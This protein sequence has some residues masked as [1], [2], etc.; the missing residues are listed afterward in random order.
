MRKPATLALWVLLGTSIA[1]A[2]A[3]PLTNGDFESGTLAGWT[4]GSENGGLARIARE[5][6][7]FSYNNTQG[8]SL[9]GSFAAEIR[10]SGPAPVDSTGV[11]T[12]DPFVAGSS[13][14]FNA[15]TEAEDGEHARF[16]IADPVTFEARLLDASDNVLYSQ[17]F[18]TNVAS[19]NRSAAGECS[20]E[21]RDASFSN[22]AIDTSSFAGQTVKLQFRQHT[23][24][25]RRGFFTLVDDVT[26]SGNTPTISLTVTG[27]HTCQ[28]GGHLTVQAHVMNP[29]ARQVH[30]EV[31]AGGRLPDGTP[32]NLFGQQHL[33][34]TLEPWLDKTYTIMDGPLP[35][36]VP[37]GTWTV[38]GTLLE[39]ELGKTFSRDAKAIEVE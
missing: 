25:P 20:G 4:A 9:S 26:L 3:V 39:L 15:L 35:G 33:E 19:L 10:S 23:N 6:S 38:E 22:H 5:G 29:S 37:A 17:V 28:E 30:V 12:S 36:G 8:L 24:V 32:V 21:P 18:R 2:Q 11:L 34:L 13:I 7:C 1:F 16:A 31:K 27:C 14:T